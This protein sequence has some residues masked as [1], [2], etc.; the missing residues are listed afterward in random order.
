MY[1]ANNGR[2]SFPTVFKKRVLTYIS[3]KVSHSDLILGMKVKDIYTGCFTKNVPG[4]FCS[5]LGLSLDAI[6][7]ILHSDKVHDVTISHLEI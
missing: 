4:R 1:L 5:I 7:F 2:L 6:A 3:M